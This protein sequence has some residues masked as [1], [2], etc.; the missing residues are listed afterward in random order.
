MSEI[1]H[2][3]DKA[4]V[5]SLKTNPDFLAAFDFFLRQLNEEGEVN[6]F[7]AALFMFSRGYK[8]CLE[9]MNTKE[10]LRPYKF[11]PNCH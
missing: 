2:E 3:E 1:N 7:Q 8:A 11:N 4:L 9:Y 6:S 5:E 10:N